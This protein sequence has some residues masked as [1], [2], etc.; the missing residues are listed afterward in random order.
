[1]SGPDDDALRDM[2]A[3][4]ADRLSADAANEVMA[5]VRIEVRGPRRGAVFGVLPVLAGRSPAV[6]AGWAAAAVVAALVMALVATRP[7]AASPSPPASAS[8]AGVTAPSASAP[9]RSAAPSPASSPVA[10]PRHVS[11]SELR[12]ALQGGSL[13]GRLVLADST[14]V[15][16]ATACP[17]GQ[18]CRAQ[19]SLEFLGPVV[20]DRR[21]GEPI[22]P[23][24]PDAGSTPL[25]G[26]FLLV[27]Y[28]RTLILVGRA[29]GSLA[30]PVMPSA[31]NG[32]YQPPDPGGSIALQALDGTLDQDAHLPCTSN[33]DCSPPAITWTYPEAQAD[34]AAGGAEL[35][36]LEVPALGIDP[37]VRKVPG[38]F[39]VRTG[40]GPRHEVVGRYDIGGYTVVDM[41]P[42]TCDLAPGARLPTCA[43][44]VEQ[45]IG[46]PE[47]WGAITS[48]EVGQGAY[49]PPGT[50]CP[51]VEP[52]RVHAIVR[53]T[54][55]DWLVQLG[56][57][58]GGN[59]TAA[60][61]RRLAS[62]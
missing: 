52:D 6:G 33:G 29:E 13:D 34:G 49:C 4:R 39:L 18:N 50:A 35:V 61:T 23:A 7:P 62:P 48:V 46:A 11:L 24:A 31:L 58:A 22:V 2:L 8:A 12:Q 47:P 30:S 9:A 36:T 51:T 42:V 57:D 25:T 41:P 26:T 56:Y 53:T 15:A 10:P 16:D 28:R 32:S 37:S 14:L 43:A 20:T 38:P 60:E 3:A 40:A 5:R 21:T 27:P 17:A 19:Y 1:M 45:A 44:I 54:L 55:G 59:L